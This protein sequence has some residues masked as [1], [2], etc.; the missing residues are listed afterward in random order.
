MRVVNIGDQVGSYEATIAHISDQTELV[1]HAEWFQFEPLG[2]DLEPGASMRVAVSMRLPVDAYGGDYS[3]LIEVHPVTGG[4]GAT[5]SGDA[6]S[7]KL[8]FSVKRADGGFFQRANLHLYVALGLVAAVM[9]AWPIRR[10]FPF[11]LKLERR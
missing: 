3:V 8:R 1:A 5:A 11:R 2:F 6:A 7:T 9:L 10:F 4:G